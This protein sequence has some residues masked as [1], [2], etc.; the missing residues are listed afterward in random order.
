MPYAFALG[1]PWEGTAK[2]DVFIQDTV[3]KI[4]D[5]VYEHEVITNNEN[6]NNQRVDYLLE[7]GK[8]SNIKI[9]AGYGEN[10]T[11]SW[12][13]TP[14]T[15][16]A[17]AYEADHPGETV[18]AGINGDFFNMATGQPMGALVMEGQICNNANGRPFFGVTKD[19][20]P[21]IRQDDNL[22]DLQMAVGG[23]VILVSNGQAIKENTAY[24]AL[25]YSRTA[26]GIKEDGTVVTFVT[27][28]LNA[29]VSCG[30]TYTE[31]A[32]MLVEEGCVSALAL[33]G[34]GSATYAGR[35]EGSSKLEVRNSP[36]DGAER[37]VSSSILIV[38]TAE[39]TG[40][41]DHAQLTPN[42]EVFTP[43]YEI[44]FKASGVDTAGMPMELPEGVTWAVDKNSEKLGTINKNTGLFKAGDLT[45][46]VTVNL[47][48]DGKAVGKTTV[49]IAVPDQIYF[50]AEEVSL[51]F[52]ESSDL[53]VVVRNK[54]RDVNYKAG[55]IKWSIS[56]DRMGT[57]D[58]NIFTSSDGESLTGT[59]RAASAWD[60]GVYGE[61]TVIVGKL[62]TVVWDFEDKVEED[63]QVTQTAQ[64]YYIGTDEK[65]GILS[66]SNYGR[67]GKESIE[68]V[69]I[70][71]DEPVRFGENSL[72]LNYDFRDCGEVTEGAC[73]GTTENL[74]VPG[75]PT[76]IGV[77]VYAP[78]GVGIEYK[79]EGSQAGFWLRGYVK[80]GNGS[81]Q[82]YDFT[83]EPK[84]TPEGEQPGIYWDGWKYLEADLTKLQAPYSIQPGMTL[85]LMYVAGTKMGTK[86]ANSIYFDNLQFVYGTNVDDVDDPTVSSITVNGEEL[87][88]GA[89]ITSEN[90]TF[91]AYLQDVQNKNTSHIADNTVRMYID[92][93]NVV[94]NDKYTYAYNDVDDRAQLSN[95]SLKDG[96]HS[97]TIY[98]KDG[99]GNEVEEVRYFT[100]ETGAT[101]PT[102]VYIEPAS[103][104]AIVGENMELLVK[105]S[106]DTVDSSMTIFKLGNQFTDYDVAF[107]DSYK[108][109]VTYSKLQKSIT[110]E[111]ERKNDV[112][113]QN[114]DVIA[115][116]SVKVPSGLKQSDKFTY[117]VEGGMFETVGGYYGTYSEK[118]TSIPIGANYTIDCEP[119]IIGGE[120]AQIHVYDSD[121]KAAT[122]IDLYLADK[123]EKIGTTDENGTLVTDRFNGKDAEAT[124]Y[125]IYAKDSD[126]GLSFEYTVSVYEPQG[127]KDG[128]PY[129]VRFNNVDDASTQKN[130]TW[131]S[132]PL[133]DNKQVLKY[134]VKG[135]DEW[136]EVEAETEQVTF[137]SSGN[138]VVNINSVE[139]KGLTPNTEYEYIL[140]ATESAQTDINEFNTAARDEDEDE[141]FIIGDIQDPDKSRVKEVAV[142]LEAKENDYDFGVQIG[143]AIDQAADY[144][145]WS[146]LGEIVGAEMLGDTNMISI[147]GNHEYYGDPE[148]KIAGTIYN[149]PITAEGG[150]Y[151]VEHGDTYVAVINFSNTATPIKDAAAWL[152][153]DAAKSDATWKILCMHQPPY[154]TNNGGNEPVYEAIPDAAEAAGI[155][156]VFSGHDHTWAVTNPLVDDKIDED[157]GI[158][159]YIVGAAGSKR[160]SPVTQDKFDYNTIFRKV[161]E[162]YTA[163]Y[164]RISSNKD[165]M[166]IDVYDTVKGLLDTATIQS[167]CKKGGHKNIYDSSSEKTTCTVC[168]TVS[169]DYTGAVSDNDGNEY[170]LINGKIKTGWYPVGEEQRY[171]GENGIRE[172]VTMEETAST[173]IV[174][175]FAIYTS[176]SG[177][178]LKVNYIDAGGHEYQEVDGRKTCSVC[179]WEQFDMSE[180]DVSLKGKTYTYNGKAWTP[181][182]TAI[183]PKGNVLTKPPTSYF[184]YSSK[185]KNNIDV[186][187][188]SV[189][190]TAAKYGF[191]VDMSQWRGNYSG[192]VT[193]EYEIR[194]T[195]PTNAE[196][197]YENNRAYLVW[198]AAEYENKVVDE[199]VIYQSADGKKWDEIGATETTK[200]EIDTENSNYQYRVFTRKNVDGKAYESIKSATAGAVKLVVDAEYNVE[201]GKPTLKWNAVEG[202]DEYKVLRATSKNG[203]YQTVFTTKGRTYTHSSAQ[204]GKTYYYKVQAII[205][206][207]EVT[208]DIVSVT[209]PEESAVPN[210]PYD[211]D[212]G[213][214]VIEEV[215]RVDG[216]N[217]YETA[218]AVADMLKGAYGV[219]KFDNIIV[220][221]GTDFADALTG[222]YLSR[223]KN[224]PILLVNKTSEN[225]TQ[226]YIKDNVNAGGTI[227][228][229][230]GEAAVSEEFEN[231]FDGYIVKRLGGNNRYETNLS[232]LRESGI[233][234]DDIL[235]C[236]ATSFADSLSASAVGKPIMLVNKTLY[237]EQKEFVSG[238]GSDNFYLI[239]GEGAVSNTV[240]SELK[241]YGSVERVAGS[242]RYATSKAVADKFFPDGSDTLL[243]ATGDAYADGLVGGPLAMLNKAPIVLVNSRNTSFAREYAVK[244]SSNKLIVVG[245]V[246]AIPEVVLN[247]IVK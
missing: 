10:D 55:D 245:G 43:G 116:L 173:C 246:G 218:T 56:D 34:G 124:D 212:V 236:S 220:A 210:P 119:L 177:A 242:D 239:G 121:G 162:P 103:D 154:Y 152:I 29:P 19:G 102:E 3:T 151:S 226:S 107:S 247:K 182:T 117:I 202:A 31:I 74:E 148:A 185:Y 193:L 72:K 172:N 238:Q 44:Q 183:D 85:R 129:N 229:L 108:G 163:T 118:E 60:N 214:P 131:F 231:S 1:E 39:P 2:G 135:T 96:L 158:L 179:G 35:P 94:D 24:G 191:Y 184:D 46:Q 16:Q 137:N 188:A 106:G 93:I 146:D 127:D 140:G 120:D 223:V 21:V 241:R 109:K 48:Y 209:C 64:E 81:N 69:S 58:G 243:I 20:T 189:T 134:A 28:G 59:A 89:K 141:F 92:G 61:V 63:G 104:K 216:E 194:P 14:T 52:E 195:A 90:I 65:E 91:D 82:P 235:I 37:A 233:N 168:G 176:E 147:M 227:Y 145:D 57:F 40:V 200:Y 219:E 42:T 237:P 110:I 88:D 17:A 78:E 22:G 190:L 225:Y 211:P 153:K 36:A 100:V 83:L 160:Y 66:H 51:G 221:C 70:D 215:E 234:E 166:R 113:S 6:G 5:Q 13:L 76:G 130:I 170:Y 175:G 123:D 217:R 98:A 4:A 206:E 232:I 101:A 222:S 197:K 105:A 149:N 125:A 27:H 161:G 203:K 114:N 213:T 180:V 33:D 47:L 53:G 205:G 169:T 62:P 186:G 174:D 8:S 84:S 143:D 132:Y 156:V 71:D 87:E 26:I 167:E 41:F 73:I 157:N 139:L 128:K 165:E 133:E 111:A 187:T 95:L 198:D 122:G 126:G 15:K 68:I 224:A 208:S 9:V 207:V 80:D 54:G 244:S 97:I 181:A 228:L 115:T 11:S 171:Y 159:Y 99:F 50:G 49:E 201:K 164:L 136:N 18:V 32:E 38:S 230:G 204:P 77:W 138:N 196:I 155:D 25:K 112:S 86:T 79:G 199:Y 150:Y 75:V 23:D 240:N 144:K 45:G 7:V 178:T 30:R 192:S 142:K 67:G 12:S